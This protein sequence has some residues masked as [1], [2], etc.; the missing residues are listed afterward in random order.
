MTE[1]IA[2][3][4]SL[5]TFLL[6]QSPSTQAADAVSWPIP[7]VEKPGDGDT[8]PVLIHETKTNYTPEAMRARV[9]GLVVMEC[10]VEV[11]G[12]VGSVRVRWS[13]DPVYG[14][15]DAAVR[16]LKQWR[17][18]PGLYKGQPVPVRVNVELTFTLR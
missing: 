6:P 12:S 8:S 11:D 14:L 1:P 4:L 7:G 18:R 2:L 10:V 3:V 17:F 9:Q 15:D 13:V 5:A 16:T